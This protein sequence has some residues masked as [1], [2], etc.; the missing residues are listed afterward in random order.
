[1]QVEVNG[2][3]RE[4]DPRSSVSDLVERLGL[5]PQRIAVE[6]NQRVI[7]RADWEQTFLNENDRVEIV[8]FV[9]GGIDKR[10][11]FAFHDLRCK[12]YS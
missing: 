4:L 9:G 5:V 1:M 12:V 7:R 6:L 8:H 10:A 11:V 2:E 3:P